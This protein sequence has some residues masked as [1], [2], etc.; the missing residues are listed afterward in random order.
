M[1]GKP[2]L[3]IDS[4]C[5]L[6]S[7]TMNFIVRHGGENKFR[8]VSLYADEGKETLKKNGFPE[9]YRESV[10]LIENGSAYTKSDAALRTTKKLAGLFPVLYGFKIIPRVIRDSVYDFVARHRHRIFN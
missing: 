7:K 10:V 2:I 6:C 3:L 9:D 5:T 1:N 8:F 4:E